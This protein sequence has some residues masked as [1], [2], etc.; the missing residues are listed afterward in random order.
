MNLR[1]LVA[2]IQGVEEEVEEVVHFE[3]DVIEL[4]NNKQKGTNHAQNLSSLIA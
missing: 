3:V 2:Q 1:L 4:G